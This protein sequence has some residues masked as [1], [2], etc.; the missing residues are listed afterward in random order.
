LTGTAGY[1]IALRVEIS[2]IG[3]R[4]RLKEPEVEMGLIA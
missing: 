4:R 2:L 1:E 3:A